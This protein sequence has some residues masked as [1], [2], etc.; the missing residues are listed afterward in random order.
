[1]KHR[2]ETYDAPSTVFLASLSS[3]AGMFADCYCG[4]TH[5]A[6]DSKYDDGPDLHDYEPRDNVV[7][8]ENI[9]GV[10]YRILNYAVFVDDCPTCQKMLL[11]YE[12][13]L[14][15]NIAEVERY[16]KL[17]KEAQKVWDEEDK[18]MRILK[19]P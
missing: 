14:V 12:K 8:H 19:T 15:E 2:K 1:M 16:V 5:I 4:I 7:I 11:R 10:S 9:D 13:F 17:R 6:K 18:L 3:G